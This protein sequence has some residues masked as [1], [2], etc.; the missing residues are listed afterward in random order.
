MSFIFLS[1]SLFFLIGDFKKG[2]KFDDKGIKVSADIADKHGLIVKRFQHKLDLK[3]KDIEDIYI[4]FSKNDT[5]NKYVEYV[6]IDM[7]NIVI[8]LKNGTDE[9]INVY[10]YNRKQKVE[11]VD[12]LKFEV[13]KTGQKLDIESGKDLWDKAYSLV[14]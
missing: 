4:E 13:E 2:V 14:K 3:Y 7:P 6:F 1:V 10:Y 5:H 11:I 9:R 12:R 8:T